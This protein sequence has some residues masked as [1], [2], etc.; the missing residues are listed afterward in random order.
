MK[1]KWTR[2]HWTT[3]DAGLL[4]WII[5]QNSSSNHVQDPLEILIQ[6]EEQSQEELNAHQD[7]PCFEDFAKI[8][9]ATDSQI[10]WLYYYEGQTLQQIAK[11]TGFSTP[12]GVWKRKKKAIK[13]LRKHYVGQDS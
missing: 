7:R 9:S 4:E 12:S 5:L 13:K 10:L 3:G 2:R 8:L 6:R 11:Q 1:D